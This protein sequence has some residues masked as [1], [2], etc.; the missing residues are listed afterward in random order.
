MPRFLPQCES[1]YAAVSFG[2]ARRNGH[3]KK[4]KPD[5]WSKKKDGMEIHL[6][7][8]GIYARARPGCSSSDLQQ[9]LN[10]QQ[11]RVST[12]CGSKKQP[13]NNGCWIS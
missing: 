10:D 2:D 5:S 6:F 13:K 9:P 3:E 7:L 12:E 8:N 1:L 4:V 11:R